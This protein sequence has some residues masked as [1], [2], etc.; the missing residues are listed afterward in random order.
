MHSTASMHVWSTGSGDNSVYAP[1]DCRIWKLE[2]VPVPA[3]PGDAHVL[4]DSDGAVW[5]PLPAE[6]IPNRPDRPNRHISQ[7]ALSGHVPLAE[8][9]E[10]RPGPGRQGAQTAP[11]VAGAASHA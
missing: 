11:S 5:A 9:A 3:G 4:S 2:Q 7:R 6:R 1:K 10:A 8:L